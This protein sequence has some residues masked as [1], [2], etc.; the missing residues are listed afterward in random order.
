[1]L[2]SFRSEIGFQEFASSKFISRRSY[3][4]LGRANGAL[5]ALG[6]RPDRPLLGVDCGYVEKSLLKK[7]TGV[8]AEARAL[9]V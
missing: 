1:L 2:L 9:Y 5:Y 4:V 3:P 8:I 6:K 7:N